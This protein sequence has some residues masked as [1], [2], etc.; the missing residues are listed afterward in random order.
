MN[1]AAG[2]R[3]WLVRSLLGLAAS[4]SMA[5]ADMPPPE[6]K[7]YVPTNQLY[8]G[9]GVGVAVGGAILLI[10]LLRKKK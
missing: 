3:Q 10:L 2:C 9:I 1:S 4:L 7:H 5:W 6:P 8:A